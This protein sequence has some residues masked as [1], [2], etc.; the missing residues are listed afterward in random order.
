MERSNTNLID[1]AQLSV[2]ARQYLWYNTYISIRIT[3]ISWYTAGIR[4]FHFKLSLCSIILCC[5]IK[6]EAI[7]IGNSQFWYEQLSAF[8]SH[9]QSPSFS[10]GYN[11]FP[12]LLTKCCRIWL[13]LYCT[14]K[15]ENK[16]Y[17]LV[18]HSNQA[19]GHGKFNFLSQW[20]F[21]LHQAYGWTPEV[22]F[23]LVKQ[24]INL[25]DIESSNFFISIIVFS[26][27]SLWTWKVHFY[28]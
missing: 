5:S 7:Y 28:Q 9:F 15:H 19:Y 10:H 20:N 12:I 18:K 26:S 3:W 25:M 23:Y 16:E 13:N 2:K 24:L 21:F 22:H 1:S 17:I 14:Y 6:L 11:K 4:Q 27:S 8:I